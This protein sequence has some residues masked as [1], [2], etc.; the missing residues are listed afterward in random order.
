MISITRTVVN[1]VNNFMLLTL[2]GHRG[3]TLI[4][5]KISRF[6]HG[7]AGQIIFHKQNYFFLNFIF[8]RLFLFIPL[9]PSTYTDY[10][11]QTILTDLALPNKI[12]QN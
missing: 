12:F 9:L 3:I 5:H 1:I 2:S 8:F 6:R 10:T 4:P 7:A 11:F